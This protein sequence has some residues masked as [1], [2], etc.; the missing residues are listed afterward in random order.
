[1]GVEPT[2]SPISGG[3]TN[4]Y[5]THH[6][7]TTLFLDFNSRTGNENDFIPDDDSNFVVNDFQVY[8]ADSFNI[9]R[10]SKDTIVNNFG[11]SLLSLCCS[12]NL[13]MLNGRSGNDAGVGNFTCLSNN[14]NGAILVDYVLVSTAL[15]LEKLKTLALKCV[16]N[17][18]TCHFRLICIVNL[19]QL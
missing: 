1:M 9:P 6:P 11:L 8:N 2:I 7:L 10:A 17:L 15:F 16:Q 14:I 13:H 3:P 19:D 18:T 12:F 4:H 5:A